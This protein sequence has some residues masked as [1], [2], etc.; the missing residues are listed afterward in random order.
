MSADRDDA[1]R[2]PPLRGGL[3]EVCAH[4][5]MIE[6]KRGSRFFLCGRAEV[7]PSFPRYPRI[8]VEQCR[9]FTPRAEGES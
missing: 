1:R 8:P 6:T 4:V 7:D 2:A 3:C 5:R 9:G